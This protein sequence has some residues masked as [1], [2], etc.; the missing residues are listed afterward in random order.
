MISK[1][2]DIFLELKKIVSRMKKIDS[3][4][5]LLKENSEEGEGKQAIESQLNLLKESLTKENK[6]LEKIINQLKVAQPLE[7][8]K[9]QEKGIKEPKISYQ[10]KKESFLPKFLSSKGSSFSDLEKHTVKRIWKKDKKPVKKKMEKPS[11]Y[12]RLANRIFAEISE[13]LANKGIFRD[14]RRNLIKS[15]LQFVPKTYISISF[16]TVLLSAIF[17]I[18]MTF[19]F[20]FFNISSKLPIITLALE[21]LGIRFLK[22]FWILFAVP[23]VTII[24]MYYYPSL[25]KKSHENKVN[26]ELP[27]A[28]IHMSAIS[29]SMIDPTKIFKI[30]IS[31]DEYP[32]ISKEFTKLLNQINIYGQDLTSAL[33]ELSFNTASSKLS[34]LLNGL[35]TTIN[36]GG[37]LA[38]FFKKR[39]ESLLFEYKI[40]RE[41]QTKTAETF[42]DI[43]IS[44]VI[45]APMIFM[46]LLMM[47]KISGFGIPLSSSM[48]SLI[49]VLGIILINIGFLVF[50][51]LKSPAK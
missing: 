34:E 49:M 27:F 14:L 41:K 3:E 50:L 32:N 40:E 30:I 1:S 37:D 5:T 12:I 28:T 43:Y 26:S 21:S 8:P 31:T 51:Q 45:A 15:N 16:F 24:V 19:F 7:K 44:I 4:M 36:S 22:V 29:G 17:G 13:K 25:E 35:S 10:P 42:M 48:I 11:T 39:A 2:S 6:K 33:R 20:L 46:L 23:I 18:F 38:E 47:M 9:V